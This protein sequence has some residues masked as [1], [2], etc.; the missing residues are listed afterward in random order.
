MR[1]SKNGFTLAELL[2]VVAIIAA[3]VAVSI[4]IF[5]SQLEKSREAADMA[6]IRSAYAR[7]MADAVSDGE[8]HKSETISLR[9][10]QDDWQNAAGGEALNS[11]ATADGVPSAGGTAWVEFK[12]ENAKVFIHY[13]PAGP[14][15]PGDQAT[16]DAQKFETGSPEWKILT[17]LAAA[18][19]KA[20]EAYE[21]ENTKRVVGYVVTFDANGNPVLSGPKTNSQ[22]YDSHRYTANKVLQN[23]YFV[24]VVCDKDGNPKV[25][26]NIRIMDDGKLQAEPYHIIQNKYDSRQDLIEFWG[27]DG[28]KYWGIESFI[29]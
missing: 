24:A 7:V 13:K 3:L 1:K 22:Q 2:I 20:L 16:L 10:K 28:Q 19:R 11:I 17:T 6:N 8:D 5:T 4:P 12:A 29:Y 15:V 26:S 23:G 18:E 9:Q 21:K 27:N 25:G 14:S